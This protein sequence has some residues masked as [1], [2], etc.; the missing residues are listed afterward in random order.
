MCALIISERWGARELSACYKKTKISNVLLGLTSKI[1][2]QTITCRQ[3]STTLLILHQP[4]TQ[5][6]KRRASSID[7]PP[8]S[9]DSPPQHTES[10]AQ[11]ITDKASR[12]QH[13]T[14]RAQEPDRS[15]ERKEEKLSSCQRTGGDQERLGSQETAMAD[16]LWGTKNDSCQTSVTVT[17]THEKGQQTFVAVRE[18]GGVKREGGRGSRL[19]DVTNMC[20]QKRIPQC[21]RV[22]T[23]QVLLFLLLHH[24]LSF[25]LPQQPLALFLLVPREEPGNRN[26]QP[27]TCNCNRL[28]GYEAAIERQPFSSSTDKS[29]GRKRCSVPYARRKNFSCQGSCKGHLSLIKND[30]NNKRASRAR[31][32]TTESRSRSRI[33]G[34]II[35]SLAPL[36]S[37]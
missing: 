14:Q 30:I 17:P 31:T 18:R 6:H 4:H 23:I 9:L 21:P 35:R 5:E 16:L 36:R 3:R 19:R 33:P 34:A 13:E 24:R 22:P 8:P 1:T 32:Q 10:A 2:R 15:L 27:R 28:F 25:V 29:L 26:H 7:L 11:S 37:L 20:H 12:K